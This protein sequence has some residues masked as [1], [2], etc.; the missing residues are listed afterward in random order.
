M[1]I[2]KV[3]ILTSQIDEIRNFYG[4]CLGFEIIDESTDSVTFKVGKSALTFKKT[5]Q[6]AFYHFAFGIPYNKIEGALSYI[7][8]LTEILPVE[9]TSK[10]AD[11]PTWNAQSFYFHDPAGNILEFIG[12]YHWIEKKEPQ[13]STTD[14]RG[15]VE[16]GIVSGEIKTVAN[17]LE[18]A[19]L[20]YYSRGPKLDDFMPMGDDNGLL[21]LC[22]VGKNWM[23]TNRPAQQF[24]INVSARENGKELELT[25]EE[26]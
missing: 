9:G 21:L 12:R 2:Q 22:A 16:I 19:G 7:E 13:F 26:K 23:P 1:H 15:I 3:S 17:E 5:N 6:D 14:I 25:I 20:T 24:W 11:F 4:K 10:I 8:E 18:N